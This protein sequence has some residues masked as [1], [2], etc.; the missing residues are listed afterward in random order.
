MRPLGTILR[1]NQ[2]LYHWA[3]GFLMLLRRRR[4]GLTRVHPTFYL[5]AHSLVTRDLVAAE[6][7]YIGPYCLVGAKVELGPYA[8]L[9]PRVS[10]V[11]DDHVFDQPH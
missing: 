9:G 1:S 8:M 3:R 2:T 11:G 10:V 4:F 5:S 6:F 7:S